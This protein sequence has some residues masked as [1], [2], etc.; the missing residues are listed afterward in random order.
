MLAF[1]LDLSEVYDA[2]D[3]LPEGY[4]LITS[5]EVEALKKVLGV[6]DPA[7]NYNVLVD[8][9]GTGYAPPTEQDYAAMVG[10]L[11]VR[12][13]APVTASEPRWDLSDDPCFPSVGDQGSVGSCSA[14]ALAYYC[15]GF[16]E[17]KDNGW[18]DASEGACGHLI[19]PSWA[20]NKVNGGTDGGS[21]LGD[22]GSVL[23]TWGGAT[24]ATMPYDGRGYIT[25]SYLD[26]GGEDAFRE[27]PCT[28]RRAWR[29]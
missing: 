14:W 3:P 2:I 19:S 23:C 25:S 28:G 13:D 16:L 21:W 29:P 26:W 1:P 5:M 27:A 17:A 18:T 6:H 15:Y 22:V 20:Y 10:K 8:G 12:S 9:H 7:R 11:V 4:H 24:L